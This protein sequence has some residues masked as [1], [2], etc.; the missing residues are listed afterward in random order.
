MW[1]NKF[2]CPGFIFFPSKPHPKGNNFHTIF[3]GE[4]GIMYG[5][6]IFEVRDHLISMGQY[7]FDRSTHMKMVGLVLQLTRAIWVTGKAVV[8]NSC[9]CLLKGI[10]ENEEEGSLWK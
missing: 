4:S 10:F 9:F 8:M 3:C 1:K 6:D 5:W 7:E 2:I